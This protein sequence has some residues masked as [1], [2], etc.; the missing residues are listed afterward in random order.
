LVFSNRLSVVH[1]QGQNVSKIRN[2]LLREINNY[3]ASLRVAK[4]AGVVGRLQDQFAET[5]HNLGV[6]LSGFNQATEW[7]RTSLQIAAA[8]AVA[9]ALLLAVNFFDARGPELLLLVFVTARFIPRIAVLNQ[10]VHGLIHDLPA[11][12]YS[13]QMLQH[14]RRYRESQVPAAAIPE[15]GR[16]IGLDGV[17][18]TAD[19]EPGKLLLDEVSLQ[20]QAREMVAIIGPSGAGKSTLADVL[21]GLLRPDKGAIVI[22]GRPLDENKVP[23]WRLGVGYV[24]Q[25]AV[26]LHDTIARNLSWVLAQ[27]APTLELDRALRCAQILH[28]KSAFKDGLSTIVE[29]S[30][31]ALSGGEQQRLAIARELLRQP[32]LLILDEATNALDVENELTILVNLRKFYPSMTVLLIAHRSTALTKADR[33]FEMAG[34]RIISGRAGVAKIC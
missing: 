31:G 26:L 9:L 34:G 2:D 11:F 3:V 24:P 8:V 17:T 22:D 4:M 10:D 23:G 13:D 32:K 20:F 16:T 29:R 33:V 21:S 14:C 25:S 1:R 28:L 19:D 12:T 27:P 5:M 15:I 7:I 30:D 6:E 18:V